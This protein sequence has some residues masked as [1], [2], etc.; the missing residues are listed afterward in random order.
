MDAVEGEDDHHDEVGDEEG[1]VEGVPAIG[2]A[3]GVV[4]V[5]GFPVVPE[6]VAGG[7]EDGERVEGCLKDDGSPGVR[8]YMEILPEGRHG[9]DCGVRVVGRGALPHGGMSRTVGA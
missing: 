8:V 7:E 5:V 3:E 1:D 6:T 4:G 2:V 9:C